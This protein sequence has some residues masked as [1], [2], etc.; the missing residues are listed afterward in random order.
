M[1]RFEGTIQE[2]HNFIGPRIRNKVNNLTVSARKKKYGICEH[3][4]Q[5]KELQSAH[6]HGNE[7]RVI[8]ENVLSRY[9]QDGL[10]SCDLAEVEKKILQ[11]HQPIDEKL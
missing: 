3:C 2:Y 11:A 4:G 6:V 10:I 5:E 8:I 9:Q 7:L 1:A